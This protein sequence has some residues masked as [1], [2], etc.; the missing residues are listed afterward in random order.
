MIWS[1][2]FAKLLPWIMTAGAALIAVFGIHVKATRAANA[3]RDKQAMEAKVKTTERVQDAPR[4]SDNDAAGARKQ[5]DRLS[6]KRK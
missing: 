2:I 6:K 4:I 5:L 3:K 1:A